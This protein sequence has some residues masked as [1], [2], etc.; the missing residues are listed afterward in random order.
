MLKTRLDIFLS[1][2]H[3]HLSRSQIKRLIEEGYILIDGEKRKPS[4]LLRGGE[5]IE[6]LKRGP[7]IPKAE[8]EA[9]PLDILFEDEDLLVINKAAG[10]VVHPAPGHFQG[11]LVS[12]VLSH[13]GRK[14]ISGES[15]ELLRPGIVHR[16][17]KG[18][19][20][21]MVVTK[22]DVAHRVVS[23]QFKDR[24]VE[25]EYEAIAFGRFTRKSG[26]VSRAIG[27]DLHH[28]QKFSSK[29]RYAREAVTHWEVIK[30]FQ[31]A[32]H[33]KVKLETG[34]T[35]QIRVHLS[36]EKHPLVGDKTY[37]AGAYFST[38]RE[39]AL[40]EC[41]K[42]VGRPMLHARRL[43]FLHPRTQERVRFE[44]PLPADFHAVLKVLP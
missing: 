28:R 9:I 21:V 33:V 1:S 43:S 42:N 35:H 13:L 30:P 44:A 36:E 34:R 14:T 5:T 6:M 27:R 8:P 26:T 40:R 22:N 24:K 7:E 11:T 31:F 29:S 25:K 23:A 19:T 12:A 37:G 17:D 10:M 39:E 32:A 3:R 4:Y 20:G 41:L 18:T 2:Q 16:L 38:I 15:P